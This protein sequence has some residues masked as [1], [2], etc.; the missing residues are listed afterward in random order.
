MLN[1]KISNRM[2]HEDFVAVKDST[3]IIPKKNIIAVG[4]TCVLCVAI[5]AP[6]ST[7][8][9]G[10]KEQSYTLTADSKNYLNSDETLQEQSLTDNSELST[11][12]NF[13]DYEIPESLFKTKQQ[14][15]ELLSSTTNRSQTD[16]IVSDIQEE[17][18]DNTHISNAVTEETPA[19]LSEENVDPQD[20]IQ[21]TT[22]ADDNQEQ[23]A[24]KD[25]EIS[26]SE[27]Q[28]A[29]LSE[30]TVATSEET[31]VDISETIAPNET[32]DENNKL[33][34]ANAKEQTDAKTKLL[35]NQ[36]TVELPRPEGKW[37]QQTVQN[38]DSLSAI[39]NL[40]D[41]PYATLNR[42]T[43]VAQAKDLRLKVGEPI[44]FLVD[45]EN[46]L[47]EMVKKISP[48][49]QVRFTRMLSTDDFNVVYEALNTHVNDKVLA[50]IPVATTMPSAVKAQK[51]REIKEAQLAKARA[52]QAARDK[53]NNV[54]PNRPRLVVDEIK[55]GESF[56]VAAHRAGLTPTEVATINK[57]FKSHFNAN[58]MRAGSK[59]RVLFSGIGTQSI[60]Y[61]V[62]IETTQGKFE[63]FINPEDRNYYGENEFTPTAGIFRRFP[64]AGSIKI[65]SNFNPT[66]R[67]PVTRRISPH[68]G[69]DFKASIG[70]PVYAP[71]DG[72]VTYSGYQRA[73]GYF[74][75][76]SHANNYSTVYMHLSKS[77]VKAGQKVIVGQMIA[78][79]GNTGRTTGPHLHYEIRVNDR[80]VDPL[81]IEL[82]TS[83]HPNLAREQR[84][85]FANNVKILR[86]DLENDKLAL[87]K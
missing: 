21:E 73:A 50:S 52:E 2:A 83:S 5:S 68:N 61:A 35:A 15:S 18:L 19:N 20:F 58:K 65:N 84:E 63:T 81:K 23:S 9:F 13:E 72:E 54:N 37:Y 45:K 74:V 64:L 10:N 7:S 38:G 57:L 47:K 62:Q 36:S 53:A 8:W 39:F 79:T 26:I 86:T 24:E 25:S 77:E 59:F 4:V 67:H 76:I 12:E 41:L 44:F 80:P 87:S 42:I 43:K 51:A 17:Q 34:V 29:A 31:A 30:A 66:R 49:E 48:T 40:L 32:Q 46:V 56:R 60:I 70:T 82:P 14:R 11:Q 55:K 71:A 78:R 27:S 28:L 22:L 1:L 16:S 69:I 85:A 6:M 33:V 75:I 3:L